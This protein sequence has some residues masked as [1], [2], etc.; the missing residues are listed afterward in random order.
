MKIC[1]LLAAFGAILLIWFLSE[2]LKNYSVKVAFIKSMV[3]SL[4]VAVG[5]CA[6]FFSGRWGKLSGPGMFVILGL[7]FGLMGDIWLDLK[8]VFPQEDDALSYAGFAVFG[9]G[10]TLPQ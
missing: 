4:F 9:I 2:K 8:F 7:V 1:T 10:R 5:I 6:W 3:S